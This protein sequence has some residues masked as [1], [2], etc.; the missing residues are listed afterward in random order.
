M[1]QPDPQA[2]RGP[3]AVERLTESSEEQLLNQFRGPWTD[4]STALLLDPL[5]LLESFSPR[6]PARAVV[7]LRCRRRRVPP[8]CST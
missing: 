8:L 7:C 3:L 4:G 6:A 5:E 1:S 2:G